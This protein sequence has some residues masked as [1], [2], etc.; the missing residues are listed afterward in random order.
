MGAALSS[1]D[2]S[3]RSRQMRIV[4]LAN[5]TMMFSRSTR[6]TGL[7]TAARVVSLTITNTSRR[8]WPSASASGQPVSCSATGFMKV[9]RPVRSV[10]ITA[11]PM[12][13]SAV[14]N[15][16]RLTRMSSSWRRFS[17]TSRKM[18]TTKR[19]SPLSSGTGL[20]RTSE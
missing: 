17:V 3:L 18:F 8:G 6:S 2:S 15:H 13:R 14:E 12:L 11:S 19:I 16:S 4:W 20:A 7:S 9:T 5:P 1:I 10:V